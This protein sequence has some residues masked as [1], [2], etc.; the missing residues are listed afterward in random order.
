MIVRPSVTLVSPLDDL[1]AAIDATPEY[2]TLRLTSGVFTP[3]DAN[4][5]I[6]SRAITI[7]GYGN[8]FI[9]EGIGPPK[10]P[11]TSGTVFT[12]YNAGTTAADAK[13]STVIKIVGPVTNVVLWNF[14]I[15]N[16]LGDPG[17][18]GT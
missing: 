18:M 2:G 8:P 5:F 17:A 4:G 3:Q 1:Q 14:G 13:N 11:Q 12:P 6:I 10:I 15:E 9:F 7:E 16:P